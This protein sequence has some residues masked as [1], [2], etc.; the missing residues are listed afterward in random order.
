MLRLAATLALALSFAAP[1]LAE[2]AV[3]QSKTQ[4][5]LTFAPLVK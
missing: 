3:P 4:I 5:E 2:E 1:A